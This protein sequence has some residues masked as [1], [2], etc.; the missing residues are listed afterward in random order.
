MAQKAQESATEKLTTGR[1]Q[2]LTT[3]QTETA[4]AHD[5]Q[6]AEAHHRQ[7]AEA[8]HSRRSLTVNSQTAL[9]EPKSSK[10][11]ENFKSSIGS[12]SSRLGSEDLERCLVNCKHRSCKKLLP[13]AHQS[14]LKK[15][16][17]ESLEIPL[18]R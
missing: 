12:E 11:Q 2:K 1:Q 5:R 6:R 9:G 17:G 4:E 7:T 16:M 13:R 3:A 18:N 10:S 8:H 15:S 14:S